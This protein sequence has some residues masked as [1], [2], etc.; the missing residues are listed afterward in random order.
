MQRQGLGLLSNLFGARHG[1]CGRHCGS[2]GAWPR[3]IQERA[4][5]TTGS[6]TVPPEHPRMKT[7]RPTYQRKLLHGLARWHR[8]AAEVPGWPMAP[9]WRGGATESAVGPTHQPTRESRG[10]GI[11]TPLPWSTDGEADRTS[12]DFVKKV[13]AKIY[14]G[15]IPACRYSASFD[16]DGTPW[17]DAS[18]C[19]GLPQ[20][21]SGL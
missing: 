16:M 1:A 18:F 4:I 19:N 10:R 3:L 5:A 20:S 6:M 2:S 12:W 7:G 14:D 9:P 8:E 15:G 13:T 21:Q 17:P 11:S